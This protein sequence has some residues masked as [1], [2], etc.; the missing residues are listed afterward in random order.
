MFM[1]LLQRYCPRDTVI[2]LMLIKIVTLPVSLVM[3]RIEIL[4]VLNTL[5]NIDKITKDKMYLT[6]GCSS[7]IIT[8][9][10]CSIYRHEYD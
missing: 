5:V 1:L 9:I 10:Q 8:L 4:L 7:T 6:S 2:V 3:C